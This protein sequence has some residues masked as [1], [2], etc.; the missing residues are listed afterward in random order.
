MKKRIDAGLEGRHI[1]ELPLHARETRNSSCPGVT[2]EVLQYRLDLPP[3]EGEKDATSVIMTEVL[4]NDLTS[5]AGKIHMAEKPWIVGRIET[6]PFLNCMNQEEP[7][8]WNIIK[9]NHLVPPSNE[10]YNFTRG[11]NHLREEDVNG[12]IGQPLEVDNL[13]Y[14]GKLKNGFFIEAGSYDSEFHSDSLYFELNHDW[15]GL[16]VEPHPLAFQEG[17]VK[18]RK[19]TSIQTCLSTEKS[20]QIMNFDLKASVRNSSTGKSEAMPGLV[21]TPGEN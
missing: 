18:R 7:R 11:V 8:L 5:G 21:M 17:L 9:E 3:V 6:R 16:L 19:A 10:E 4:I 14:G 15:T 13:I 12:E 20:P 1:S 2:E